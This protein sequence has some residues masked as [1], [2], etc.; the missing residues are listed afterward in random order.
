MSLKRKLAVK[1]G[2][3]MVRVRYKDNHELTT[4]AVCPGCWNIRSRR[5]VL[6]VRLGKMGLEVVFKDDRLNGVYRYEKV[7]A[8]GCPYGKLSPNPWKRF[9]IAVNKYKKK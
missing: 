5:E 8:P 2:R 4:I 7:H 3:A 9:D 6:L 1:E